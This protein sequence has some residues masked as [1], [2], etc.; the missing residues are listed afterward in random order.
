MAGNA[1]YP[2]DQERTA[3]V[4]AYRNKNGIADLLMPRTNPLGKR[5]YTY[6]EY[7]FA[8]SITIPDSRIG[9]KS[10]ANKVDFSGAERTGAC[11]DYGL[12]SDIPKD[13]I[14]N[15]KDGFN[16][17]DDAAEQL[18]QLVANGR[19]QR[20]AQIAQDPN[21]YGHVDTLTTGNQFDDDPDAVLEMLLDYLDTPMMRP[22]TIAFGQRVWT[23]LRVLPGLRKAANGA[24]D[25]PVTRQQ[26]AELL[27]VSQ[28][29]VGETLL[30]F[31][32][33]GEA[34]DLQRIWGNSISM[35]YQ[36]SIQ[37]KAKGLVWGFTAQYGTRV[38]RSGPV[39]FGLHGGT[40]LLVGESL[41]EKVCAKDLGLLI[42]DPFSSL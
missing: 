37:A 13:D 1:P 15:A 10:Q 17:L 39:D 29:L 40:G 30:N 28:V 27:E 6:H 31:R 41:D 14:D 8:R 5:E 24:A 38:A 22:N 12:S 33:P 21:N 36:D 2:V 19:E 42:V 7:D 9:R 3:I 26:L 20:V 32:K 16:P 35:T 18:A 23:K 25:A 4:L 11:V 34:P